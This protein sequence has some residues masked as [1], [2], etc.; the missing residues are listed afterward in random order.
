HL[1]TRNATIAM[2]TVT[3]MNARPTTISQVVLIGLVSTNAFRDAIVAAL[4]VPPTQS[5]LDSQ[6]RIAVTGPAG[7]PH[8]IRARS[9]GPTSTGNA[10]P[11]SAVSIP[12][13]TRNSTSEMSSHVMAC[14]PASAA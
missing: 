4:S 5:G 2:A 10:E 9:H 11:S 12:Y 6:Y 8:D 1:P 3:Q 13:G 14:A 7:R